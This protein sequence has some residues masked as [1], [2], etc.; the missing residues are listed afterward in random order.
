[1]KANISTSK[2]WILDEP[3]SA[4]DNDA[5]KIVDQSIYDHI[6]NDG[7]VIMSNHEP[8]TKKPFDIKNLELINE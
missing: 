3:Y 5:I 6:K 2:V 8:I 4:L 7:A 1:M